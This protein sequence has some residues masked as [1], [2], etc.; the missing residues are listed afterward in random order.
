LPTAPPAEQLEDLVGVPLCRAEALQ[1]RGTRF[2][3]RSGIVDR[4]ATAADRF[5]ARADGSA[6][7]KGFL[8]RVPEVLLSLADSSLDL[9]LG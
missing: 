1:R 9:V 8:D 7:P 6:N 5:F 3:A 2:I 4:F